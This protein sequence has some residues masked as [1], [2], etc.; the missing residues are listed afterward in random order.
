[1]QMLCCAV[2]CGAVRCGVVLESSFLLPCCIRPSRPFLAELQLTEAGGQK[3]KGD[4]EV[5][6]VVLS[7]QGWLGWV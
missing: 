1:M 3:N 6:N 7:R 2:R 5:P 4:T